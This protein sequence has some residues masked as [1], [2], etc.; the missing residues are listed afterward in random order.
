MTLGPLTAP[1]AR[2]AEKSRSWVMRTNSC[3]FAHARISTSGAIAA[4]M[5]DPWRAAAQSSFA[6]G[7]CPQAASRLGQRNFAFLSPPGGVGQGLGDVL[8]L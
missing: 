6:T 8:G 5:V 1:A 4:P 2:I 7:S 3:S